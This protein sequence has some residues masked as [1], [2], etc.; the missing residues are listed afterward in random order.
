[1]ESPSNNID[2]KKISEMDDYKKQLLETV[3]KEQRFYLSNWEVVDIDVLNKWLEEMN[4]FIIKKYNF[5][6]T[7]SNI[8]KYNTSIDPYCIWLTTSTGR[9]DDTILKFD[10]WKLKPKCNIYIN[11]DKIDNTLLYKAVFL[12]E[13]D[14][15]AF[16]IK[17]Y[18]ESKLYLNN[19]TSKAEEDKANQDFAKKIKSPWQ[20]FATELMA[21]VDTVNYLMT[22]WAPW[23]KIWKY[24]LW[25]KCDT[26]GEIFYTASIIYA[27]KFFK[28]QIW[29]YTLL[30]KHYWL[31]NLKAKN[32]ELPDEANKHFETIINWLRTEI[33]KNSTIKKSKELIDKS[34][35]KLQES[36]WSWEKFYSTRND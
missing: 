22:Q 28:F 9:A 35:E 1:M 25:N 29:L 32:Q 15:H 33:L 36:G 6:T 24:W 31:N 18:L 17:K 21:R 23:D 30:G 16:F 5:N 14:H 4:V 3:K 27:K 26:S 34:Y 8:Y 7:E 11:P 20:R 2:N 13:L 12:H 10:D 19:F